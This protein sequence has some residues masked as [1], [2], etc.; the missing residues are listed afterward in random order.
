[1]SLPDYETGS[2]G[3]GSKGHCSEREESRFL[4]TRSV[5]CKERPDKDSTKVFHLFAP[6]SSRFLT[7]QLCGVTG[8]LH[9]VVWVNVT[10]A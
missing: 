9:L 3:K 1:M 4:D 7:L 5:I 8:L 10:E 6:S 2:H